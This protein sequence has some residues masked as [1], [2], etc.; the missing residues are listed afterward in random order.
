MGHT[1]KKSN[2]SPHRNRR[3]LRLQ[4]YDYSQAG[5]Y[6]V[7]LCT[8]DR[9]DL[10]GVVE[11]GEMRLNN[12]GRMVQTVWDEIP[13]HYPGIDIDMF[14]IMPDH[15]HG[16]IIIEA[17]PVAADPADPVAADPAPVAADPADP[18][19]ADTG[20]CPDDDDDILSL[21][22]VVHRFKTLTTKRYVDGVKQHGWPPFPG[23]VWQR[24]YYEHIIR[25]D[26]SLNR[27]RKYIANNPMKWELDR[28]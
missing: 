23:R 22:D 17:D 1:A 6:F 25:N 7:T 15:I 12:A 10:F 2:R 14:Q 21:S 13:A 24:N 9:K 8:Q 19:A 27:I 18:V 16:I 5:A 4:G 11:N 20:V 26:E 28:K 3:S